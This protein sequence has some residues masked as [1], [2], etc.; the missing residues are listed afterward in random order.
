VPENHIFF[1]HHCLPTSESVRRDTV[2]RR[3]THI[4]LV[5]HGE[6][7]VVVVA[8]GFPTT[9]LQPRYYSVVTWLVPSSTLDTLAPTTLL[10]RIRCAEPV[11]AVCRRV[12]HILLVDHGEA[13]A[14]V[15][16]E[17]SHLFD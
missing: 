17:C 2:C 15:V 16:A 8:S 6:A 9:S 1:I 10:L 11:G 4:L 12:T 3:V 14:V 7:L 13:L 5:D